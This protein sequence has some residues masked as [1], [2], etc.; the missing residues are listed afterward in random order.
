M[1]WQA[2]NV[3]KVK[4]ARAAW[5]EKNKERL[6]EKARINSKA[7]RERAKAARETPAV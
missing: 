2:A 4:A 3:D 1:K 6:R 5:V 7:R